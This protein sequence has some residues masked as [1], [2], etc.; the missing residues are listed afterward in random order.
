MIVVNKY[1]KKFIIID[2]AVPGGSWI[3]NK[4]KRK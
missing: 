1:E 3:S 4:K 2:L